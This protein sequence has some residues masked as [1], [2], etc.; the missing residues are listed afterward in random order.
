RGRERKPNKPCRHLPL[1]LRHDRLHSA[2]NDPHPTANLF[3]PVGPISFTT[4][5]TK[6]CILLT[7]QND[8]CDAFVTTHSRP[9][10]GAIPKRGRPSAFPIP[11]R[12]SCSSQSQ[13]NESAPSSS[14][15]YS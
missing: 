12:K 6:D 11:A 13:A 10:G 9:G 5:A 8:P 2:R 14:C 4:P 15:S 7:A 1:H 3:L